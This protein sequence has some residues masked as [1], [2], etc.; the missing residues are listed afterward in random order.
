MKVNGFSEDS[1]A[2][3]LIA[4]SIASGKFPHAALIDG[5]LFEDRLSI[6]LK[7]ASALVCR[8]GDE[9]PCRHCPDC[10]KASHGAHPDIIRLA[11]EKGKSSDKYAKEDIRRLVAD[12]YTLPNEAETKVYIIERGEILTDEA[13]NVLLKTLEEPVA[14]AKFII[15]CASKENL[16]D[17]VL[18]RV[19]LFSLGE[20]AKSP[21]ERAEEAKKAAEQAADALLSPYE[22][23]VVRAAAA[24]EGNPKLLEETLP[25][26]EEIFACALRI[27]FGSASAADCESGECASKLAEKLSKNALLALVDSSEEL[28]KSIKANANYNLTTVRFCSLLRSAAKEQE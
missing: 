4:S 20:D 23:D 17:T 14:H 19:T 12:S 18:S 11:P 1:Y 16:L 6:A 27:K 21:S 8:G 9:K 13:Q 26:L 25:L 24:F 3:N 5:G 15:L 28:I 2:E 7:I 10:L 22:F